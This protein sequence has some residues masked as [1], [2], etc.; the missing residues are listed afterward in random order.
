M[1]A[2]SHRINILPKG[3]RTLIKPFKKAITNVFVITT[4]Y[5][6]N[7]SKHIFGVTSKVKNKIKT[8]FTWFKLWK[9]QYL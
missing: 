9:K 8:L 2:L 1:I 3:T 6:N 5:L 4:N 7:K